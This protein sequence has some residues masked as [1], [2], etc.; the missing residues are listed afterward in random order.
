MSLT[1][2]T[3]CSI[4][5]YI[6]PNALKTENRQRLL[7]TGLAS[8]VAKQLPTIFAVQWMGAKPKW[9]SRPNGSAYSFETKKKKANGVLPQDVGHSVHMVTCPIWKPGFDH[10]DDTEGG[11][12]VNGFYQQ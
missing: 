5:R 11:S 7:R 3:G 6:V 2:W 4:N 8:Q 10:H 9:L 1:N 12:G